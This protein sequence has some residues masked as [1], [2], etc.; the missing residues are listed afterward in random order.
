MMYQIKG[1]KNISGI[2]KNL[3]YCMLHFTVL[4][5]AVTVMAKDF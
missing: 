5:V 3:L 4:Q 2:S 1:N